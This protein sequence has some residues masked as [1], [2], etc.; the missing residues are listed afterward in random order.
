MKTTHGK[1]H[2]AFEPRLPE[3]PGLAAWLPRQRGVLFNVDPLGVWR[4]RSTARYGLT[5]QQVMNSLRPLS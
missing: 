3:P 4:L 2:R 1:L 5:L